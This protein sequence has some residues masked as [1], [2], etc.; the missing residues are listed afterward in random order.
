MIPINNISISRSFIVNNGSALHVLII[1][2]HVD[3]PL[4]ISDPGRLIASVHLTG[5]EE[6]THVLFGN[7]AVVQCFIHALSLDEP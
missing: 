4:G 5:G 2:V 6:V 3:I 1:I 7:D